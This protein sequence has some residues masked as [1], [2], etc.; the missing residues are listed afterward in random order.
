MPFLYSYIFLPISCFFCAFF[1][2]HH[3]Y[4]ANIYNLMNSNETPEKNP[5]FD[6]LNYTAELFVLLLAIF[7]LSPKSDP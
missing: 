4:E 7:F 3:A 2:R 1:M 5:T 6:F